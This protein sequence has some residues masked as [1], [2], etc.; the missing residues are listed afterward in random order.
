M[1]HQCVKQCITK[2]VICWGKPKFQRM[3]NYSGK[4]FHRCSLSKVI[5]RW[6]LDRREIRQYDALA[7]EDHSYEATRAERARWQRNWKI[8]LNKEGEEDMIRQRPD[9]REAKHAHRR[10][11]KEHVESTGQGNTSIHPAHQRRGVL[12]GNLMNTR[13]ALPRFTL[14]LYGDIISFNKFVCMQWQQHDDWKSNQSR[15]YWRSLTWTKQ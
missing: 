9:F 4:L 14:E 8:V 5:V 12:G 11:Y 2:H 6:R 3:R 7:L 10:L 15:D 1:I 13:S